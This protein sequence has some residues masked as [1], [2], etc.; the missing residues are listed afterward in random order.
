MIPTV[1]DHRPGAHPLRFCGGE[2][3]DDPETR[4]FDGPEEPEEFEE[5]NLES[6]IDEILDTD[7]HPKRERVRA[8]RFLALPTSKVAHRK[9]GAA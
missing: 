7:R 2:I 9:G 4:D 3:F 6:V 1:Y 8:P 5:G